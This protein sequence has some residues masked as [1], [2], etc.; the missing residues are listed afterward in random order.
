MNNAPDGA[1]ITI[2]AGYI[3]DFG[4]LTIN[5]DLTIL[6]V[7]ASKVTLTGKINAYT[8]YVSG[9]YTSPEITIKNITYK[10]NGNDTSTGAIRIESEGVSSPYMI[11]ENCIFD[12]NGYKPA[13]NAVGFIYV[14]KQAYGLVIKNCVFN[15]V[16]GTY[17]DM[18][19]GATGTDDKSV[20]IEGNTFNNS[21]CLEQA[22]ITFQNIQIKNNIVTGYRGLRIVNSNNLFQNIWIENNKL[23]KM[24]WYSWTTTTNATNIYFKGNTN[25]SG[26]DIT[27]SSS[28]SSLITTDY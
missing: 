10:W 26:R 5:K 25:T 7:S 11:L 27:I 23:S 21:V 20:V 8:K 12:Y 1:T 22:G 13:N 24:D 19:G 2:G 4:V 16:T 18:W 14:K 15:K 28:L 3:E 6:G 17:Y 9:S